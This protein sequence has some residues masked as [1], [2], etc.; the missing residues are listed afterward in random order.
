MKNPLTPAGIEPATFRFV[1]QHLNHRLANLSP[2]IK[3]PGVGA[4]SSGKGVASLLTTGR[5]LFKTF[6]ERTAFYKSSCSP[7][8]RLIYL[9]RFSCYQ[10]QNIL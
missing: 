9:M 7:L 4:N 10:Q 5:T 6:S 8:D 3:K 1:A 2:E